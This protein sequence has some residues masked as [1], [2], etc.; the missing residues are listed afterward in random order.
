MNEDELRELLHGAAGR[1]GLALLDDDAAVDAVVGEH[2][3]QR[4]R[5]GALLAVAACLAVLAVVV[6]SV[7]PSGRAAPDRDVAQARAAVLDWPTRGSL[8]GDEAAL[9]SV[10]ALPWSHPQWAPA[11]D[12]RRVAFLGD[13]P[14]SRRALVVGPTDDGNVTG[15]WFSGAVGADP[16]TLAAD[17]AVE[18]L[19]D[20]VSAS[21]VIAPGDVLV[22]LVAP[23]DGVELSERVEVGA[24]GSVGRRFAPVE[25]T[26]GVAVAT[27]ARPSP[28][29]SSGV[30]RVLHGGAVVD[31][32]PVPVSF[33][34]DQVWEP[35]VLTP[36]DP[37]SS[38]P[39]PEAVD[40]ALNDVL[41]HTGLAR[42]DVRL[43]L[44]FSGPVPGPGGE[45][46]VDGVV[47]A[48]T[49]PNGAVVVSTAWAEMAPD[50]SGSAGT[51]GMQAHPAGTPV[52]RLAV[53]AT[54]LVAG[55]PGDPSVL[56]T[57]AT[58]AFD[59]VD[60]DAAGGASGGVRAR[61]FGTVAPAPGD[62]TLRATGAG[63]E[64]LELALVE[65]TPDGIVDRQ[66]RGPQA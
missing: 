1:G 53:G 64:P 28:A 37:D 15:Q 41:A 18:V 22:V 26:D 11:P 23:G 66:G 57:Y 58:P 16:A 9:A 40:L 63:V 59:Q 50:G 12:E 2:R 35:P 44:L 10:R 62:G 52:D 39:V 25:V 31:S 33:G 3:A 8:A 5:R 36:L 48:V 55:A 54:C 13:V 51:C 24:D 19:D 32:R 6:P 65:A 47:L 43:D 60:V 56:V 34:I 29:G 45:D 7:W 14:G 42:E 46:P 49:L 17:G 27:V 61:G 20:A 38:A 30:V 4:R 21:S